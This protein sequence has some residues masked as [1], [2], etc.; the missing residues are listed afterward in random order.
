VS[1]LDIVC[2]GEPMVE[3]AETKLEGGRFY[4]HGFGGDTS[5]TAIAAA[6]QGARVGYV[7]ALGQ[8]AFGQEILDLLEREGVDHSGVTIRPGSRTGLYFIHYGPDGH[9]FSYDRANSAASRFGV[10]DLP[11][12]LIAGTRVLHVSGI[13]QAISSSCTDAV[14]AA[15]RHA[16]ASGAAVS[17]DTN[18][19]LALWP[20]ERAR[21]TIH[22]AVALA[23]IARPGLDDARQLTGLTTPDEIADFYLGLG[24]RIVAL[25]L[26]KDGTLVVTA[27]E[28]RMIPTVKVEAVDATGAGDTFTGAFLAEWLVHGDPFRAAEYGNVAAALKTLGYGAIAPMPKRE[29]VEARLGQRVPA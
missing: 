20:L 22:A 12:D 14:F 27:E 7:T 2:M 5:N 10:A 1:H 19:R 15:I 9:V 8:D 23:D 16:K 25:T 4:R 26:G 11:L 18:L 3:F 24:C 6:R 29:A 21:A 17:Y 13:S 28:R